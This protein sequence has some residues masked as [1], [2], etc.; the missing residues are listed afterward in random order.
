MRQI[1][2]ESNIIYFLANSMKSK[3]FTLI[4]LMIVV[5]IIG[6][7]ASIAYPS[8]RNHIASA[9]RT[10]G[11]AA[12]MDLASRMERFYSEQQSYLNATVGSGNT[13]TDVISSKT[14]PQGWYN[15]SI[16]AQTASSYTLQAIPQ[17][18]QATADTLC[19]TLTL[20]NLGA[21]GMIAG[22]A[23]APTGQVTDC[24]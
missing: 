6:I 15:L 14:S 1:R 18:S 24:W 4:E 16:S 20:N 12:L 8:Y 7:I 11:Q 2:L 9:R 10:D 21:K 17:S 19:Q 13:A 3:G 23:G 22:P 5:A